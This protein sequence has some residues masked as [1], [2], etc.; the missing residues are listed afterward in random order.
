MILGFTWLWEHN[1]EVDWAWGKVAMSWCPWRCSTCATEVKEERQAGAQERAAIQACRAGHFPFADLDLLDPLL[2]AFPCREA[3][4][5]DDQ[6][7]GRASEDKLG[8][9]F[10]GIH[11]LEFPD[12]EVEVGDQIYATTLH[13]LLPIKE[14]H[15]SQTTSQQLAQV[16]AT[17]S[18][19]WAFWD[20][21]PQYF[22][23]FKDIFSK[24]SFDSLL[25]H[26]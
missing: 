3:L 6:S 1:P 2:L 23:C 21:V 8:G 20:V 13:L 17:N 12:E 9:E 26:K 4:Y 7:S 18:P 24:A 22:H 11:H 10:H 5:R 14:I 25:E 16:F 15:A 19:P